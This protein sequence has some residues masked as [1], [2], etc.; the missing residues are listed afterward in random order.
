M[1]NKYDLEDAYPGDD[2]VDYVALDI[3]DKTWAKGIYPY[4]PNAT[5]DEKLKIQ[6]KAWLDIY[7]C[8]HGIKEWIAFAKKHNKPFMIPEWG[9]W[10]DDKN[11]HAGFDNPISSSRCTI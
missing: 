8:R 9:L 10:R 4:P 6:K 2:V 5:P 1:N 11:G 7:N 3:Y